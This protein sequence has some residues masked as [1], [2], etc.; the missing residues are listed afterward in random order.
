[1]KKGYFLFGMGVGLPVGYFTG[2]AITKSK[3][4]SKIESQN[5]LLAE[6]TIEVKK[7]MNM[8]NKE[9]DNE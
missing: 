9:E 5:K 7:A 4:K 1:M 6:A 2:R 8:V 3:F